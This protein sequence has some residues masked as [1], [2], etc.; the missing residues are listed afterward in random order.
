MTSRRETVKGAF[1]PSAPIKRL[2][3]FAGRG[4]QLTSVA[5]AL[6]EPGQHVVIYGERGV[7]K[8]SLATVCTEILAPARNIN[9]AVKINCQSSDNFDSIWRKVFKEIGIISHAPVFGFGN[10]DQRTITISASHYL[11]NAKDITPDNV[12][13]GLKLLTQSATL[14]IFLDEFDRVDDAAT[15][16]LFADLLKTLSDEVIPATIVLVGVADNVD[17]LV[18]EHASIERALV[19]VHMPR[20]STL[21]LSDIVQKGLRSVDM[22]AEQAAMEQITMLSQGLPHY[23]HLLAQNAAVSAVMKHSDCIKPSDVGNAIKTA[24]KGAQESI[25]DLYY[26][27]TFSTQNNMYKQI[28]LACAC[29]NT[30]EKGFF[31]A[32]DVREAL[33]VVMHKPYATRQF[34]LHLNTLS[35]KRGPVLR[36]ERRNQKFQYRFINPLFQPYVAMC[37]LRDDMI[38]AQTLKRLQG[39]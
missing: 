26:H 34:A 35:G 31:T 24:I 36:R 22:R 7:G 39:L 28:L 5:E 32:A 15:H 18:R 1:S 16:R 4:E 21:E 14:A 29:A 38:D 17:E 8:T 30:D 6:A 9:N 37:G 11:A 27:A 25:R 10:G 33:S 13:T 20:M 23:T 2:D 12:R 19:Q 3:L